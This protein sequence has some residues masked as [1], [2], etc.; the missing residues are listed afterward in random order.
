MKNNTVGIPFNV[1]FVKV[2]CNVVFLCKIGLVGSH[3]GEYE[4]KGM[5]SA[6]G[7]MHI[8]CKIRRMVKASLGTKNS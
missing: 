7:L 1:N 5:L 3:I 8:D 4:R 2:V 6:T